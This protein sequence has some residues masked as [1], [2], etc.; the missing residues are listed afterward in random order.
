[1]VN[2]DNPIAKD[3]KGLVFYPSK[4]DLVVSDWHKINANSPPV[5][6]NVAGRWDIPRENVAVLVRKSSNELRENVLLQCAAPKS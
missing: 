5:F 2:V 1:M 4:I 6:S 3:C